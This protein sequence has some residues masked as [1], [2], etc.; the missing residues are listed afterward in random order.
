MGEDQRRTKCEDALKFVLDT[1][2]SKPGKQASSLSLTFN[3]AKAL[4]DGTPTKTLISDDEAIQQWDAVVDS[5][6]P[7]GV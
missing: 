3:T 2:R 4:D 7:A 5:I 6:R 1:M